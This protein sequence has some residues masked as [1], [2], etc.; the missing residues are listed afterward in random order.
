[1]S[2]SF[3][4]TFFNPLPRITSPSAFSPKL[5]ESSPNSEMI[6]PAKFRNLTAWLKLVA[7]HSQSGS[8]ENLESMTDLIQ[9]IPEIPH[10]TGNGPLIE[11]LIRTHHVTTTNIFD[12]DLSEAVNQALTGLAANFPRYVSSPTPKLTFRSLLTSP[13]CF[14]PLQ[15]P[16]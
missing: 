8:K 1:M 3:T 13:I 7:F 6:L 4:V 16:K 9:K 11:A 15:P 2:F 5:G 12:A 14:A 10:Y